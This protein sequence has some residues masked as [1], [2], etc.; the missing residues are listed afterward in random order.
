MSSHNDANE[1]QAL[2]KRE[3]ASIKQLDD[4]PSIHPAVARC[5]WVSQHPLELGPT[6]CAT[7]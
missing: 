6:G 3:P 2:T 5:R 7:R 4:L 1:R